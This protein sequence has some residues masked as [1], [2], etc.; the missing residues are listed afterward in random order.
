MLSAGPIVCACPISSLSL[1]V[2]LVATAAPIFWSG[3]TNGLGT[4][5][6]EGKDA[7]A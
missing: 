3:Q 1:F 2:G 5:L 4:G 6:A 7:G